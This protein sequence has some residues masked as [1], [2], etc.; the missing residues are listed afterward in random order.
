MQRAEVGLFV[1]ADKCKVIPTSAWNIDRS[2]IQVAGLDL[3]L[4][5]TCGQ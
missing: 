3:E 2:D 5:V 1:N 4:Q